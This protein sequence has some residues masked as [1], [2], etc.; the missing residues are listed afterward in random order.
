[1][2][3]F[4]IR[5]AVWTGCSWCAQLCMSVWLPCDC[6]TLLLFNH[7]VAVEDQF[8]V[9]KSLNNIYFSSVTDKRLLTNTNDVPQNTVK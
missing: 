5:N 1:M 8:K 2:A 9:H 7:Q 3:L 6:A 4:R